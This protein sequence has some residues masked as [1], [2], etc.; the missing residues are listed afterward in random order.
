MLENDN[1]RE[2]LVLS[3]Q[4]VQQ[5]QK[6]DRHYAH[7]LGGSL[8]GF[9]HLLQGMPLLA[10][11]I[12]DELRPGESYRAVIPPEI[13]KGLIDGSLEM[14]RKK[15]S[16]LFNGMIRRT[17]GR[18]IIVKQTE[19]VQEPPTPQ[20]FANLQA[21]SVQAQVAAVTE[22]LLELD[23]KLEAVLAGQHSDRIAQVK[24][25]IAAYEQ[26]FYSRDDALKKMQL[27][28]A[29][30]SLNEGRQRL[31]EHLITSLRIERSEPGPW[32]R[33]LRM[34]SFGRIDEMEFELLR[35][36][37]ALYPTVKEDIRYVNL[38]TAYLFRTLVLLDEHESALVSV[39]QEARFYAEL[40]TELPRRKQ[41][42]PYERESGSSL[43][44]MARDFGRLH[45]YLAEIGQ[46][47]RDISLEIS[48][49]EFHHGM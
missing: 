23:K 48:Y 16:G 27:A 42:F 8:A 45:P 9:I 32:Q 24:A 10:K 38:A 35:K 19:W 18:K 4:F 40:E 43:P 6:K 28:N 36:F 3:T 2:S 20:M 21:M 47:T 34:V 26:A 11:S 46:P 17:D 39:R 33:I 29:L 12:T 5:I 41:L 37:D 31:M 44:E 1:G 30:Q 7:K 13:Q 15:G 25:G 49:E 22:L 14:V